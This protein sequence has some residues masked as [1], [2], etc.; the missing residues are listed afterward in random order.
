MSGDEID[1]PLPKWLLCGVIVPLAPLL[2]VA[3]FRLLNEDE[4]TQGLLWCS[5]LPSF[6]LEMSLVILFQTFVELKNPNGA[7]LRGIWWVRFGSIVL[8]I[9]GAAYFV[10]FCLDGTSVS[11]PSAL[12]INLC[13]A[14]S[15]TIVALIIFW[16]SFPKMYRKIVKA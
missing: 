11:I 13:W 1:D 6:S 4:L 8:S 2:G 14:L 5:E 9:P 7:K 12:K 16:L 3:G 15:V 10:V